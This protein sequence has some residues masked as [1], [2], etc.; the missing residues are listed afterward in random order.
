MKEG[1]NPPSSAAE[2]PNT[3]SSVAE[4]PTV[5]DFDKKIKGVQKKL[6][7][8]AE[9]KSKKEA[10]ADLDEGQVANSLSQPTKAS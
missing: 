1:T 10:G 5:V 7:Q 2:A 4:S 6:K 9:L 3:A 8:I